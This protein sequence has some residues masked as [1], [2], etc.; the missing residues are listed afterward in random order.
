QQ[1][2][3][4]AFTDLIK[5]N[6]SLFSLPKI[7][8][9][10]LYDKLKT[11][12]QATVLK[13]RAEQEALVAKGE[14]TAEQA[15]PIIRN[16]VQLWKTIGVEWPAI[17]KKHEEYLRVYNIEFDEY[18]ETIVSE[19]RSKDDT[20]GS[21]EKIDNFRK[22][23]SAIKLLLGTLPRVKDNGEI[24][25]S[26]IAGATLLPASQVYITLLNKLHSSR[27]PDEMRERLKELADQDPNYRTLYNRL[28]KGKESWTQLEEKHDGQLVAAFWRTF[29][30]QAP[31][32]KSVYILD[33]GV[34]EVGDSNL[35]TAA[36]QIKQEFNNAMVKAVKTKD[37]YF[38]YSK[39]EK[40]FVGR[41][42][43]VKN[44]KLGSD[45]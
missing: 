12:I 13:I 31:D 40:A 36:R 19:D 20:Y 15:A 6:K 4:I 18:D 3:Y 29:K 24:I 43:G 34:V 35:S 37:K 17:Q 25:H 16:T 26:S 41:A 21:A 39:E 28:T 11:N 27:T 14:I 8:K 1:M 7:N 32:V 10:A 5:D 33:N 22:A 23:N 38:Q 2:T 44:I 9:K 45:S 30:K 42:I